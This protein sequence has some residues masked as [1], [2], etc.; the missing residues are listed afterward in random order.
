MT[1]D[2]WRARLL[3]AGADDVRMQ[4]YP[5]DGMLAM[6]GSSVFFAAKKDH[7][8]LD[9]MGRTVEWKLR[10]H[11]NAAKNLDRAQVKEQRAA[12]R[13]ERAWSDAQK[14]FTPA[15]DAPRMIE[16]IR[17]ERKRTCVVVE[18]EHPM[19]RCS[20][21]GSEW[22]WPEKPSE[23][24]RCAHDDDRAMLGE[25]QSATAVEAVS[26]KLIEEDE[27]RALAEDTYAP[28]R[29]LA[30]G[31]VAFKMNPAGFG[32]KRARPRAGG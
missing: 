13:E 20:I 6:R 32:P 8:T 22:A 15:P 30:S 18:I 7:P 26:P 25:L 29:V 27:R 23:C 19:W 4:M 14:V 31:V 24:G 16:Q 11:L 28:A 12:V 21:C 10:A 9:D 1:F 17:E 5:R 3:A 2:E